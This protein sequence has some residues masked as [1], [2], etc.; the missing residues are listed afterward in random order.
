MILPRLSRFFLIGPAVAISLLFACGGSSS[1]PEVQPPRDTTAPS[2]VATEAAPP[3]AAAAP[4]APNGGRVLADVQHLA[5][6][7]GPRPAGSAKEREAAEFVAERLR[8]LGYDVS[9]QE[10]QVNTE[11]TRE[12]ALSVRTPVQKTVPTV[13]F[14]QS[15]TGTIRA[16]LV[17][18]GIGKPS[19]FPAG[20]NG[21]VA[22]LER[23]ELLF[24]EKV[25]NAQAAGAR[26]VLIFNNETGIFFGSLQDRANIPAVAISQAEGR[27][28]LADLQR[29]PVDVE[30]TVGAA[31][32]AMSRN[33]I[34]KPPGRDC[35]TV[36]G[37]HYD[38][39]PQAP[40]ASDNATGTST[41]LEMASIIAAKGEMGGNCFV[42]FGAEELGLNGSRF[43][44]QS[45][46]ADGRQR[47]KAMLNFDMVGVGDEGWLFI[48]NA[49]LQQR[50]AAVASSLGIPNAVRGQ[51][52]ATTSSDHASFIQ[53][54]I[55]AFMLHRLND[56]L[57]H[58]PQDV[59]GRVR[60]ELLEDAVR[61]GVALLESL[62]AGG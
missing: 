55:P 48:G 40:G 41:V 9:F 49:D 54:G 58:T 26:G 14:A 17:A 15:G 42:L 62:N 21:K 36:S 10:F 37:G 1:R 53:A 7:I 57:L 24:A 19:D 38:S 8:S 45:L 56:N 61:L 13:P 32:Q 30:L 3:A 43:F 46:D 39:V 51:L 50:A 59:S 2:A 18:A 44:V 6:A 23:G 25:A 11:S 34:A 16:G 5:D 35:A 31:G 12:S 47:L 60:P 33:V 4:R 28:L 29:G 27:A 22:L 20:T 52:R